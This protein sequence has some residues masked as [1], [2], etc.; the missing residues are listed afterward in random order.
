MLVSALAAE[1]SGGMSVWDISVGVGKD[2]SLVIYQKTNPFIRLIAHK[3]LD[4]QSLYVVDQSGHIWLIAVFPTRCQAAFLQFIFLLGICD[5]RHIKHEYGRIEILKYG[6]DALSREGLQKQLILYEIEAR[7]HTPAHTIQRL[8]L[9]SLK[10]EKI[11][12]QLLRLSRGQ[13]DVEHTQRHLAAVSDDLNYGILFV[14]EVDL[15]E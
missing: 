4:P 10:L 11:C 13:E 9:I 2:T 15:L 5:G 3:E 8:K 7:F 1:V 6:Y 14:A 12:D